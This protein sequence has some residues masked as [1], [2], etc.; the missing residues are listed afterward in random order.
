MGIALQEGEREAVRTCSSL[1]RECRVCEQT[2]WASG[3][4]LYFSWV[5]RQSCGWGSTCVVAMVTN[6]AV[7][8]LQCAICGCFTLG[9]GMLYSA[10]CCRAGCWV[11]GWDTQWSA[12]TVVMQTVVHAYTLLHS[13]QLRHVHRLVQ[14][15]PPLQ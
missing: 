7:Q 3:R 15:S 5:L 4:L 13:Q 1:L 9:W 10:S 12:V 6:S 2:C 8:R 11:S 14:C